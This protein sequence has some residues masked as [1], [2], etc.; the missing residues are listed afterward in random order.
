MAKFKPFACGSLLALLVCLNTGVAGAADD[1]DREARERYENAVKLYEEGAYD[2]ALVELNRAS[3]LRPS[4]KIY[5]NIGQVR[6]AMHDYAAA[7]DAYRHYLDEGGDK[8]PASR[9][10]QVQKELSSLN[11]RVAKLV[12]ETDVSG[13]EVFIDD[14]S[15]GFTPLRAPVVVNS[16]IRRISA[17]HPDYLPQS[18]KLSIA[19]GGQDTIKF[20]LTNRNAAA[21]DPGVAAPVAAAGAAVVP[22]STP[23]KPGVGPTTAAADNKLPVD[24][25]PHSAPARA[26]PWAG[27]AL[28][29]AFAAGATVTGVLA[30]SANSK[31]EDD[32]GQLDVSSSDVDSQ[33]SKVRTLATVTDCL[34]AAAVV[35]GGVSLWLTLRSPSQ[36]EAPA[37]SKKAGV[38]SL[39]VGFA[40]SGIS[41]KA[42]F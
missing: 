24:S 5:Y 32:R 29:G 2:A 25:A 35:S 3:E 16:G 10:D 13:A 33:A 38:E 22:S 11:Q 31:L 41:M 17:R 23:A 19:G 26:I 30:L 27:W 21:A 8:I 28:T 7:I 18:R 4:Y 39:K 40:P 1:A 37:E 15:V 9:R 14:V 36:A 6:F 20:A 42:A 12:I 34:I